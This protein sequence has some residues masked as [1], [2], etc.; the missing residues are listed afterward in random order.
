AEK[1]LN[2]KASEEE[3]DAQK[4]PA[5][6]PSKTIVGD[7]NKLTDKEKAEVIEKVKKANPKAI[8]VAVA[9]NGTATLTY[10]DRSTN[11][12]EG[13]KLVD[14]KS[15]EGER[16]AGKV[17]VNKKANGN[18]NNVQTGVGSLAGT[19]ATLT[20]AIGGLFASKKKKRK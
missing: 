7:K 9:D 1:A 19:L 8:K 11:T 4:N 16:K 14:K 5:V 12:I 6:I 15:G 17:Y 3:T 10:P 18:S 13:S 2:G 20:T